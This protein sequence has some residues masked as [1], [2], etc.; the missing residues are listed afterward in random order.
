MAE[1]KNRKDFHGLLAELTELLEPLRTHS[2]RLRRICAELLPMFEAPRQSVEALERI[3][4]AALRL[5]PPSELT[6]DQAIRQ[7]HT[8]NPTRLTQTEFEQALKSL[9]PLESVISTLESVTSELRRIKKSLR[10]LRK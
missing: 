3:R 1:V 5:D 4:E 7:A 8:L 6:R 9:E 10:L 2:D